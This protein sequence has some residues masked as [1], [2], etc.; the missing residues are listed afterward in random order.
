SS[1]NDVKVH[2]ELLEDEDAS[3]GP[4]TTML[5]TASNLHLRPLTT[6][7]FSPNR[8]QLAFG[9]GDAIVSVRS[10]ETLGLVG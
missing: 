10:F 8:D 9:S 2:S 1:D 5:R 3:S 7:A 6:V 4:S